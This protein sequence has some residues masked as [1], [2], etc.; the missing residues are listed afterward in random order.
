MTIA[1]RVVGNVTILDL[2][3]KLTLGD[4]APEFRKAVDAL[5]AASRVK[6]VFD[7]RHVG[8]VDS[9]GLGEIV[10]AH[11]SMNAHGGIRLLHAT[12]R[13]AM[14]LKIT[15]LDRVLMSFDSEEAAVKSFDEP[16]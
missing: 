6:T 5:V 1:E 14:L 11:T 4:G 13:T 2:E 12:D 9:S 16:R 15:K 7:L 8:L 3:G 10:R